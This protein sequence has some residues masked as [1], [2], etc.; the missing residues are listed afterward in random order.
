MS[1][2]RRTA[3]AV[4]AVRTATDD[5]LRGIGG[6]SRAELQAALELERTRRIG[7]Q[8]GGTNGVVPALTLPHLAIDQ[9]TVGPHA[10][11]SSSTKDSMSCISPLA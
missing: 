4:A 7:D 10:A 2:I 8:G 9:Q 11:T 3:L 1:P 6:I 5:L